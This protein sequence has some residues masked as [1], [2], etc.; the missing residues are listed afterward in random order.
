M[1][2]T[3]PTAEVEAFSARVWSAYEDHGRQNLPWRHT[4]DPYAVLVSEVM[5][6]QTQ[7]A[8]VLAKY[9]A[10]LEEFPTFDALAAVPLEP[11]LV[12]WQGLGYNRRALTLK[13]A[14]ET[15]SSELGGVLSPDFD[16]RSL[17]GIGAATAAGVAVFAFD[18]PAPYLETNVRAVYLH[19]YFSDRTDVPD[20]EI[21]PL[22]EQTIDRDRPREWFYAL[23]DYGYWLKRSLPNPSRRSAHHAKQSKFEG[24]RRQKRSQLLR[25]V[26]AAPG[27]TADELAADL[28]LPAMDATELLE[29]L[30]AEGFLAHDGAGWRVA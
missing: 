25:G 30:A 20:R 13:R 7:V 17:P 8:R 28:G 26:M 1:R 14:A 12:A 19:E 15:V 29:E 5:L 2:P 23:L 3:L 24:S 22:L 10:W 18:V 4:R 16:L 6:Q 9:P 11:V 27:A 21:L